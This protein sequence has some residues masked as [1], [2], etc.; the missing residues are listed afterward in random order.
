MVPGETMKIYYSLDSE[1]SRPEDS[2]VFFRSLNEEVLTVENGYMT[3]HRPGWAMV[4]GTLT[5]GYDAFM[6]VRVEEAEHLWTAEVTE[7]TCTEGG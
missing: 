7:P 4:M 6:V 5:S 3:A 1:G 2:R